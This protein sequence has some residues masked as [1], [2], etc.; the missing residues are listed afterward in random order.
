MGGPPQRGTRPDAPPPR[1][2]FD[3][4][5]RDPEQAAGEQH[6]ELRHRTADPA[7]PA[8]CR[9]LQSLLLRPAVRSGRF[10]H[11]APTRHPV[12]AA[13][14][15]EERR[16]LLRHHR[17]PERSAVTAEA[18]GAGAR[19]VVLGAAG[20]LG[21]EVADELRRRGVDVLA[22]DRR[23]AD[24]TKTDATAAL[25]VRF[26]AA[27]VY[28]CAASTDV[29]GCES[30]PEAAL[31]INGRAPARLA[32]ALPGH[33]R[34]IH[35]STDYVFDGRGRRPYRE[36]D[37]T[38]P[39][40]VYGRSKLGAEQAVVDAGGLVV[41]TSWV[42][43]PEGRNFVSAIAGRLGRG[44]SLR[45][46]SDQVGCPTYAPYLARALV[47]LHAAGAA[48]IVH[49]CNTPAT[50]WHGFAVDIVAALGLSAEVEPIATADLP[51]PAVRPAY[52]VLDTERFESLTNRRVEEWRPGLDDYFERLGQGKAE[53]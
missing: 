26:G 23:R 33:C 7:D 14:H 20:Q 24:L 22:A 29:D 40:T 52:S 17:R 12:P 44:E 38:A 34:L 6:G 45:V 3:R 8:S 18:P 48:G 46:V 25:A 27:A 1:P 4:S 11:R 39:A 16:R 41:R 28:N 36:E 15:A 30:E 21:R 2:G 5:R 43:G 42:F 50:S 19:A 10:P 37:A 51:R 53:A 31:E 47:D 13:R 35:V 49:Y 32:A 9:R